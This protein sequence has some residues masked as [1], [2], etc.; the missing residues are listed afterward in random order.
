MANY[1]LNVL[2]SIECAAFL[3]G[4]RDLIPESRIQMFAPAEVQMLIGGTATNI[5]V[6]DWERHTQYG[7]GYHPS[8]KVIQWFWEIV[9][10]NFTHEDRAAPLKFNPSCSRQPLLGFS[11]LVPQIGIHQVRVEYDERLPSSA[12]CVNLLKLPAYSNKKSM[13]KEAGVCYSIQ[14]RLRPL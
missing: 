12:T 7:G 13:R 2:T 10:E 1:K 8:Q 3:M 5:D 6:D 9:K 14:C 4:F 11:K